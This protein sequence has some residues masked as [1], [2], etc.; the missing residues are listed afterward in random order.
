MYDFHGDTRDVTPIHVI[1]R[2]AEVTEGSLTIHVPHTC[3]NGCDH[4]TVVALIGTVV[5]LA[6]D[7]GQ[8]VVNGNI[9]RQTAEN[10]YHFAVHSAREAA[11]T[12]RR[13]YELRDAGAGPGALLAELMDGMGRAARGA[14]GPPM[15]F[16]AMFAALEGIMGPDD[17][18]WP[19]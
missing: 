5:F 10:A 13:V 3:G 6:K 9:D 1:E 16:S 11:A 4:D 7:D 2:L 19:N 14:D 17:I 12:S 8:V 15:D 18:V